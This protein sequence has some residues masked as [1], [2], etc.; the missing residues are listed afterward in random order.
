M[1][2]VS[3]SIKSDRKKPNVP[4]KNLIYNVTP[5]SV[6]LLTGQTSPINSSSWKE[7]VVNI[8]SKNLNLNGQI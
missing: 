1:I 3:E 6:D 2:W 4:T 8:L 7:P 5:F